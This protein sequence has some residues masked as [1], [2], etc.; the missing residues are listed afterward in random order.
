LPGTQSECK[1]ERNPSR[2]EFR[3]SLEP[4]LLSTP[5]IQLHVAAVT[6]TIL[7]TGSILMLPRGRTAHRVLGWGWVVAMAVTAGSSFAIGSGFSVIHL[8]SV[9][10][11]VMLVFGIRAARRGAVTAH[12]S[13][14]VSMVWGGLVVAGLFTLLPGR[15]MHLVVFGG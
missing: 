2:P 1:P 13:T 8:L 5:M 4:L 12:R 7:L 9:Y 6:A 15:I 10:V 3:M 14:M 11:L